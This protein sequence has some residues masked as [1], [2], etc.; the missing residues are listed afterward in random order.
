MALLLGFLCIPQAVRASDSSVKRYAFSGTVDWADGTP[1]GLHASAGDI[2]TGTFGYDTSI[3]LIVRLENWG[4]WGDSLQTDHTLLSVTINGVTVFGD[5]AG[6]RSIF[7]NGYVGLYDFFTCFS[8]WESSGR[9]MNN[10]F[11]NFVDNTQQIFSEDIRYPLIMN[12]NDWSKIYGRVGSFSDLPGGQDQGQ[13]AF[14]ITNFWLE[15]VADAGPAQLVNSGD[16]VQLNGSNSTPAG[17]IFYQWLQTSGP[18]VVLFDPNIVRPTFYAPG[19]TPDGV[20]L[21]FQL[22]VTN[23]DGQSS[24]DTCTVTVTLNNAYDWHT[25]NG[26]EYA[27]TGNW[28]PWVIAEQEAVNAGGHLATVND[29]AENSW[30]AVTFN[31]AYTLDD[32]GRS[33][34]ARG[35]AYIGYY[36]NGTAWRW[37][38]GEP[39]SYIAPLY[40]GFPMGGIHGYLHTSVHPYAEMWNAAPWVTEPWVDGMWPGI[41]ASQLL[42]GIIERPITVVN[43]PPTASAGAGQEVKAGDQVTLD[44]SHSSDPENGVF[45]YLWEQVSGPQVQL[46]NPAV[47]DPFFT[48]PNVPLEGASLSFRLTVT[49]AGGLTSTD[50]CIVNVTWLNKPPVADA[51]GNQTVNAGVQVTLNGSNS[52]DPDD[53]I[54]YS[55]WTQLSGT[56]SV[57]LSDITA[58]QPTFSAP[59]VPRAGSTLTFELTVTDRGNLSSSAQCAVN[60]QW[61]N[62]P[63]TADA[64]ENVRILSRDQ[65]ATVLNGTAGDADGDSLMYTW[66][67]GDTV[68]FSGQAAIDGTAPLNLKTILPLS[69]GEHILTLVVSDGTD[70]VRDDMTLAMENSAPTAAPSGAGTYE[71]NTAVTLRGEVADYDGDHVTYTWLKGNTKLGEGTVQTFVGGD[72]VSLPSCVISNLSLGVHTV[73]LQV[74]DG[75]NTPVTASIIIKIDDTTVP[76]LAPIADKTILWPPNHQIVPVTIA[77]HAADNSGLPVTLKVAIACNEAPDDTA[78][79]TAP[80][81]NQ[82]AGIISMQFMADRS[83]KGDGRQYTVTI[84]ATD[85][86]GNESTTNVK[87]V[88]PHDQGKK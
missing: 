74:S 5:S 15:P 66:K 6:F 37:I 50:T 45:F 40:P 88:V 68:F 34:P 79:W 18:T 72:P 52:T 35:G 85:A 16:L 69:L 29:A 24:Q 10:V 38:S 78:Y 21:V 87:I 55:R 65:I 33:D 32:N 39:V 48:A 11:I 54:A 70:S 59:N 43:Q 14:I 22:T 44:G 31:N 73:T 84:T 61:V 82:A 23:A 42:K 13:I 26:H 1:L 51:G 25:Y 3:P 4:Y 81:I 86:D 64:G 63:P 47:A 75:K 80:V 62:T 2:V 57:T 58:I 53:G 9:V 49:D 30:L 17:N 76:T 7:Q 20:S 77:A 56:P 28:E 83:G 41:Y 46:S 67:E 12:F 19:V 60:V 27:L 8:Q 71:I 36:Y